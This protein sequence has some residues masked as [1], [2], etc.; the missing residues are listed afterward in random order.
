MDMFWISFVAFICARIAVIMS[1]NAVS[2]SLTTSAGGGMVDKVF[3]FTAGCDGSKLT[4]FFN[5]GEGVNVRFGDA[6]MTTG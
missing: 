2:L 4:G 6:V 1:S 3:S 5:F